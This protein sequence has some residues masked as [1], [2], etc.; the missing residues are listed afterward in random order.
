MKLK[1][2]LPF[3]GFFPVTF[4]FGDQSDN[5]EIKKKFAQWG[6][7]GHHGIDY[8]LSE[9]TEV[10]SSDRGKV[11]QSSDSGEWGISVTLQHPWGISIYAHLQS[12][13]VSV[14]DKVKIGEVVGLSGKTGA[15]FGEHLHFG[16]KL[17]KP[18]LYNGY[19]GFIDPSP[20]FR[21]SK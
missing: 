17:K 6:I 5:K 19:L 4:P 11:I 13:K 3:N 8:G 7:K 12:S 14:G 1:L 16:I 18:D 20:Y 15:A 21:M 10:L 9:G 2:R